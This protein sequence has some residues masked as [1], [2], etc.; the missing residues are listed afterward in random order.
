[1]GKSFFWIV[2][3]WGIYMEQKVAVCVLVDLG[4][5][6]FVAWPFLTKFQTIQLTT[7]TPLE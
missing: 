7:T 6:G 5:E 1:M 2:C 4:V 3:R